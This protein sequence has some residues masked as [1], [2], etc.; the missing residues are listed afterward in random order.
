MKYIIDSSVAFK[1]VVPEID[2]DKADDL[3]TEYLLGLHEFHAPDIFPIEL[4][5]ALTRAERQLRIV[6]GQARSHLVDVFTTAPKIQTYRPFLDRAV[7]IS[8]QMRVGV[9]DCVYV[10]LAEHEG[11]ELVTG[12]DKLVANLSEHFP[13]IRSLSTI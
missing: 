6:V 3:R 9:Y 7:E 2:S 11:C 5:H 12:D 4:A 13:F 10:A 8:S 1:W